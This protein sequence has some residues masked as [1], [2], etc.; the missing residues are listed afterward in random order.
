MLFLPYFRFIV[1]LFANIAI[2][3]C[4]TTYTRRRLLF[5]N[6]LCTCVLHL[7]RHAKESWAH[8]HTSFVDK[9]SHASLFLWLHI[10]MSIWEYEKR[11]KKGHIDNYLT[12]TYF[13]RWQPVWTSFSSRGTSSL[14]WNYLLP[15][16]NNV[17][18]LR[19][20]VTRR[21]SRFWWLSKFALLTLYIEED[22]M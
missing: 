13:S 11:I 8:R 17:N 1:A 15:Q 19:A 9:T 22:G 12:T 6:L 2:T 3:S 4:I 10:E 14:L 18:I 5:P 21:F 7:I 16:L 20:T